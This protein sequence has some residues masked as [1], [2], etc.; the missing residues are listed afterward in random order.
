MFLRDEK[1]V[2]KHKGKIRKQLCIRIYVCLRMDSSDSARE[3]EERI[4]R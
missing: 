2:Y 3:T 4:E 1:T